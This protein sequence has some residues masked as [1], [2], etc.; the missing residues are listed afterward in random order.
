MQTNLIESNTLL[1]P[2]SDFIE[3]IIDDS[4]DSNEDKNNN[5]KIDRKLQIQLSDIEDEK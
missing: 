1:I 2:T 3:P 4:F 5:T